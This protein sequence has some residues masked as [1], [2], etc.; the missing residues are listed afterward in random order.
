VRTFFGQWGEGDQLFAILCGRI[1]W[2]APKI[3]KH[4][5]CEV[6]LE[7]LHNYR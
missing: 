4:K 7:Y 6:C 3:S 1:L 2:M 5:K